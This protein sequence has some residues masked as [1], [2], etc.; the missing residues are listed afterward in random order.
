MFLHMVE[1]QTIVIVISHK[2]WIVF[3]DTQILLQYLKWFIISA[4]SIIQFSDFYSQ[5][6]SSSMPYRRAPPVPSSSERLVNPLCL[7]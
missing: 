4:Q 5:T 1:F 3:S 6:G 7:L 2:F